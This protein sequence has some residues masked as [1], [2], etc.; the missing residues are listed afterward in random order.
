MPPPSNS[1]LIFMLQL[2][3]ALNITPIKGCYWLRA[4]PEAGVSG[5]R[6]WVA[7]EE[8]ILSYYIG[9]TILISVYIYIHTHYG[10]LI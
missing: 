5:V 3:I 2:Y 9:E 8:L 4:V 1:W 6:I 10:K 7:V